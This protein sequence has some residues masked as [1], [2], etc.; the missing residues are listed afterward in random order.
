MG[1]IWHKTS[2][3]TMHHPEANGQTK[4]YNRTFVSTIKMCDIW[5]PKDMGKTLMIYRVC[6]Q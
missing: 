5:E 2:F 6:I 3:S 1:R 4:V